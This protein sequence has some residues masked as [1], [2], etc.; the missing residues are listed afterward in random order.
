MCD[1]EITKGDLDFSLLSPD[2]V[3]PLLSLGVIHLVIGELIVD[4][5]ISVGGDAD[6][7]DSSMTG[8]ASGGSIIIQAYSLIGNYCVDR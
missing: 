7:Q 1:Q 4:G 5:T 6:T 8:G 2:I 3:F